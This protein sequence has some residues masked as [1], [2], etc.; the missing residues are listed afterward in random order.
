V[1]NQ[2]RE[3]SDVLPPISETQLVAISVILLLC[4]AGVG[5]ILG[6]LWMEQRLKRQHASRVEELVQK[7]PSDH[8]RLSL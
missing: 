1:T 5:F 6:S 4:G 7:K 8:V 2:E 3:G